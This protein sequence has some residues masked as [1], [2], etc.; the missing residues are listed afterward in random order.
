MAS[1]FVNFLLV[2]R[3]FLFWV[4]L[5]NV[6]KI[7]CWLCFLESFYIES[8]TYFSMV[9]KEYSKSLTFMIQLSQNHRSKLGT[10]LCDWDT[11]L[12]K[13]KKLKINTPNSSFHILSPWHPTESPLSKIKNFYALGCVIFCDLVHSM[14]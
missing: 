7:S 3:F 14:P 11:V 6:V 4:F 9:L 1:Y 13:V 5:K 2:L 12:P 8:N 10:V